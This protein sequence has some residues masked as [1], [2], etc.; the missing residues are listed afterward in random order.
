MPKL[1]LWKD[2]SGTI[3]PISDGVS[4]EVNIIVQLEFKLT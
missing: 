3:Q 2:I 1:S 4:L